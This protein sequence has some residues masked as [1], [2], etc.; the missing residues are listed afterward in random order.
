MQPDAGSRERAAVRASPLPAILKLPIFLL[1]R[2][3]FLLCNLLA[4]D[5][6]SPRVYSRTQVFAKVVRQ[7]LPF[8]ARNCPQGETVWKAFYICK[9][10]PWH[11]IM[12]FSQQLGEPR[13]LSQKPSKSGS[14]GRPGSVTQC[15]HYHCQWVSAPYLIMR[16]RREAYSVA[17]L[18]KCTVW[19]VHSIHSFLLPHIHLIMPSLY[20]LHLSSC[21]ILNDY[22]LSKCIL[23]APRQVLEE[24]CLENIYIYTHI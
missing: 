18:N 10:L 15:G 2:G 11:V 17:V 1:R 12:Y 23:I 9:M 16:R 13:E 22:W 20:P 7:L 6:A 24:R 19:Q 3:V 21:Y 14:E 5:K 8:K 4:D